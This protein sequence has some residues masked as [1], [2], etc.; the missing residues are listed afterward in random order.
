VEASD[1]RDHVATESAS[2]LVVNSLVL[3]DELFLHPC[4]G[5]TRW[6]SMSASIPSKFTVTG[7]SW[8]AKLIYFAK[9]ASDIIAG[10]LLAIASRLWLAATK[11]SK[12]IASLTR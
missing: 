1:H 6:A 4:E 12:L 11:I 3:L 9:E 2:C 7:Y 10:H 8:F 5:S